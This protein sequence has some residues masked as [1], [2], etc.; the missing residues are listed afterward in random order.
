MKMSNR[1]MPCQT[2]SLQLVHVDHGQKKAANRV[3]GNGGE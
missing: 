1:H 3:G 2:Q